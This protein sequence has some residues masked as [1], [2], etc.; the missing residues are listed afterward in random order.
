V[1]VVNA[2]VSHRGAGNG[3]GRALDICEAKFIEPFDTPLFAPEIYR[4]VIEWSRAVRQ[5]TSAEAG[6]AR[7]LKVAPHLA[8]LDTQLAAVSDAIA[9]EPDATASR[10]MIGILVDCFPN[11]RPP[12]IEAYCSA[13][14]FDA[15]NIGYSPFELARAC[16]TIRRK[17]KFAPAISELL[18]ACAEAREH[19]RARQASL[20]RMRGVIVLARALVD[21]ASDGEASGARP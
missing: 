18:E 1:W 8:D 16:R 19:L 9:G 5:D 21:G 7:I 12:N 2:L 17:S 10:A 14:L 6:A 4:E 3:F 13:L 11:S 15:L 20:E